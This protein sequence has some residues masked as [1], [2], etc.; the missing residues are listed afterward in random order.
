MRQVR[1]T[2]SLG[3]MDLEEALL[4]FQLLQRTRSWVLNYVISSYLEDR[5]PAANIDPYLVSAV[6]VDVALL[7]STYVDKLKTILAES[8][9]PLA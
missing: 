1:I 6:M 4:E 9:K 8:A 7:N 3:E 2:N 5:R